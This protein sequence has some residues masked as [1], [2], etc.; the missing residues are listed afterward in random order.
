MSTFINNMFG[1]TSNYYEMPEYNIKISNIDD[2]I[3]IEEIT[4]LENVKEYYLL[5]E[6]ADNKNLNIYDLDKYNQKNI[7]T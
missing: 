6:T 7:L 2:G 5:Y 4:R 1:F 3:N